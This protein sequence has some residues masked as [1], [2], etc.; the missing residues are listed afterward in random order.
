MKVD[1][2]SSNTTLSTTNCNVGGKVSVKIGIEKLNV[3]HFFLRFRAKV[4]PQYTEQ[5][6][7]SPLTSNITRLGDLS[8]LTISSMEVAPI[9]LVP[10]ASLF[11]KCVT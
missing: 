7:R 10:L 11:K 5:T 8:L 6:A 9:M 2:L 3:K 4:E 1:S